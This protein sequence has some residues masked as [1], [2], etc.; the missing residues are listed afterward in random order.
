[1]Q[2][3]K[4]LEQAQALDTAKTDLQNQVNAVDAKAVQAQTDVDGLKVKAESIENDLNTAKTDLQNQVNTVDAKAQTL[5]ADLNNSK[6]DILAQAHAQTALDSR[7]T[8]VET[9]A[10]GTKETVTQ[11]SKTVNDLSGEVTSATQSIKTVED[12]I[13]GVYTTLSKITL[14]GINLF[15]LKNITNRTEVQSNGFYYITSQLNANAEYTV[16]TDIP[17]SSDG[18]AIVFVFSEGGTP[19]TPVNGIYDSK[20]KTLLT[21]SSGNLI[22][23]I[24][25]K[26]W[27]DNV[28]NGNN[29][30]QIETGSNASS[31]QPSFIDTSAELAE[32]K[33][34]IDGQ[35]TSLSQSYQT[36]NGQV[37]QNTTKIETTADSIREDLSSLQSYVD[38]EGTRRTEYLTM[39]ELKTA[40]QIVAERAKTAKDYVAKSVYTTDVT[41]MRAD[42]SETKTSLNTI[43][44]RTKV[45]EDD[46][47]GT[48]IQLAS[49]E[50][51]LNTA[52]GNIDVLNSKSA[53]YQ[54]AIDGINNK[55]DNLRLGGGNLILNS[56]F[57]SDTNN[58]SGT[59]EVDTHPAYYNGQ[60][61]LFKIKT[62]SGESRAGTNR[63]AVKR[64]TMYSLSFYMLAGGNVTSLDFFFLGRKAGETD[65]FTQTVALQRDRPN[66]ASTL[67]YVTYTFNSGNSDNGYLRFDNNGSID[68]NT[69]NVYIAEIMLVE[70]NTP[71]AHQMAD[72]E[73][74]NRIAEY[75]QNAD[76]NYAGLQSTVSTL[77]GK[78]AQNKTEANQTATQLSNRLTSLE[79][80]KDGEST[81][82][83][84]YFEASK[85]ETAKQLTAERTCKS[86]V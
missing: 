18:F 76:Q 51:I 3:D 24:K 25:S 48:K 9:T 8:T 71:Q 39:S 33:Q 27:F 79:T 66:T 68:G 69:A 12:S 15:S 74:S 85:T 30:I 65:S 72:V 43:S 60:K 16:S 21:D 42:I 84:S 34:S 41:S 38:D 37:G 58:W 11:L 77:D 82:A 70:G 26:T 32:Y 23:A 55:F 53:T 86:L 50:S 4:I 36:L 78:V 44:N 52:T 17:I 75:K 62:A 13:D 81:R 47:S 57:Q 10:N 7:V 59:I 83:Q 54:T 5:T 56:A 46:L 80:Y 67:K 28:V 64:N 63:F 45:V 14:G 20:P 19:S 2:A 49:A 40:E 1:M 61:T 35:L 29:H 22:V 73:I 6:N 31:W